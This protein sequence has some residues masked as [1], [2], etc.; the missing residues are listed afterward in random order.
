MLSVDVYLSVV[1][2]IEMMLVV[3]KNVVD[4]VR[5][6]SSNNSSSTA[7]V[8]DP[9]IPAVKPQYSPTASACTGCSPLQSMANS[10]KANFFNSLL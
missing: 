4:C 2:V 8:I 5:V 7:H 1:S 3:V 9:R 6:F 10:N